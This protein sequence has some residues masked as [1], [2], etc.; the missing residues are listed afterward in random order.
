M[1]SLSLPNRTRWVCVYLEPDPWRKTVIGGVKSRGELMERFLTSRLM[2]LPLWCVPWAAEVVYMRFTHHK[3]HWLFCH[4]CHL[5]MI[6][7]SQEDTCSLFSREPSE[8]LN[9]SGDPLLAY[10]CSSEQEAARNSIKKLLG[11]KNKH[12]PLH[13]AEGSQRCTLSPAAHCTCSSRSS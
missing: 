1:S 10:F 6:V 11:W 2:T 9:S 4:H 7:I 3:P 8:C 12:L 13:D 5:S